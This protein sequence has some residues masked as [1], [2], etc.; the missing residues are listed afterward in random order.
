MSKPTKLFFSSRAS[1]EPNQ[2]DHRS[3]LVSFVRFEE[4]L[5]KYFDNSDH[6][7]VVPKIVFLDVDVHA[8]NTFLMRERPGKPSREIY[9]VRRSCGLSLRP[10]TKTNLPLHDLQAFC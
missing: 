9:Y 3:E 5:Q 6:F 7:T 1:T 10:K 2:T 4:L 8:L